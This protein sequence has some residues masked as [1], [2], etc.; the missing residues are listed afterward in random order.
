MTG[1]NITPRVP[2]DKKVIQSYGN[3]RFRIAGESHEGSQIVFPERT[4]PWDARQVD[5]ITI[6]TLHEAVAGAEAVRIL[7]IGCGRQFVPPPRGLAAALREHG[8]ILE[9]MDTGAA[10]RTFNVLL[11][12]ER[13]VCAALLAID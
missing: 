12:E 1:L 13:D 9:W 2:S 5:D 8:M 11:S 4:A 10:C 7:L 6:A 3:G